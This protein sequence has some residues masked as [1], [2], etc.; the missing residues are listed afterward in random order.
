MG[1]VG[2]QGM[3]GDQPFEEHPDR[4]EV[5]F[6]GGFGVGAAEL[7]DVRGNV[8]RRH[9]GEIP[10]SLLLTPGGK[11]CDGLE[12]GATGV[13]IADV[14]GEELP[15]APGAF[16]AGLEE[17][18]QALRRPRGGGERTRSLLMGRLRFACLFDLLSPRQKPF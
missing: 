4:G 9:P 1:R 18:R 13:R 6:D 8:H 7:L 14:D 3:P 10:Q 17:D 5:L 11:S 12:V 16:G 15:K 2:L